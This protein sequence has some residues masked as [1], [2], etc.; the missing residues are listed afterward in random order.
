MSDRWTLGEMV[1]LVA[2]LPDNAL[3]VTVSVWGVDGTPIVIDQPCQQIII[4][5]FLYRFQPSAA[6]DFVWQMKGT[7]PQTNKLH[8]IE[9]NFSYGGWVDSL[10]KPEHL[11]LLA[12]EAT[13][14]LKASQVAVDD[15]KAETDKIQSEV[16]DK[17][18]EF[19][20]D[21]SNLAL[22]ASLVPLAKE[23]SLSLLASQA[24]VDSRPTLNDI[25]TSPILAK[26]ASIGSRASQSSIDSH[27][28]AVESNIDAKI[29]TRATPADIKTFA[30]TRILTAPRSLELIAKSVSNYYKGQVGTLVVMSTYAGAPTD[31][32]M[33]ATVYY[34][35]DDVWKDEEQMTP[36]GE[37]GLYT[38]SFLIPED[39][40]VGV[41][42]VK[43]KATKSIAAQELADV[44]DNGD[45]WL[46]MFGTW[47]AVGNV[48]TQSESDFSY[49]VINWKDELSLDWRNYTFEADI[50]DDTTTGYNELGIIIRS[51]AHTLGYWFRYVRQSSSQRI[52]IYKNNSGTNNIKD[53][54]ITRGVWYRFKIGVNGYRIKCWIDDVLQFDWL[55]LN[56][57][58]L[59]DGTVMVKGTSL[60]SVKNAL[61][62]IPAQEYTEYEI[63][64]FTVNAA[65][66]QE[67]SVQ[68]VLTR[69]GVP[70]SDIAGDLDEVLTKQVKLLQVL[71]GKWEVKDNQFIM[72]DADGET[73]LY[74]FD[75]TQD[76]T[77]TEYNPDKRV[78]V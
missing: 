78:L 12:K 44:F 51:K 28:T 50:R 17:K 41:Y 13:L 27:R 46:V 70:T 11:D 35:N 59:M 47:N 33:F 37:T 40:P 71:T 56:G 45:N 9:G 65:P 5:I 73:P 19:K 2:K 25:E 36:L 30:T 61:I 38:L 24:S 43:Y 39:A 31:V 22:E 55:D 67:P 54:A 64:D 29:S 3:N 26:E 66:A 20:A 75:L 15:I 34:P 77:P 4:S 48:F 57:A 53:F 60:Y 7:H 68:E 69:L 42:K 6:G 52:S 62:T 58:T 16:L 74:T 63:S 10:L 21:T 14:D 23:I 8:T 18:D 49:K 76:G 32:D 1:T 72:Y